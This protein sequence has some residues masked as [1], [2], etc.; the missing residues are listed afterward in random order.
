MS[1]HMA[2]R[3][4]PV[5]Q[6]VAQR[7]QA[8]TVPAP[9]RGIIESENFSF[10][11]PGAAIICD[12]WA[13]TMRGVKLRGG[14]IRW[15]V[16][17]DPLP[18]LSS[19]EYASGNVQYMFA[20]QQT[21]LYDVTAATPVLVKGGQLSGNY[22]AAQLATAA[23]DFLTAVND[24]GDGID[25]KCVFA[26]DQGE[27]LI[28]TGSNPSD[29]N[30]WRQEGRY[31]IPPPMGINAHI[32]LGGDLLIATVDG[33]VPVS[34]AITKDAEQLDLAMISHNIRSLWRTEAI[35]KR[36]WQ[37]TMKRWDE[38]GG[39]FVT[40]PGG[41]PGSQYCAIVNTGT[42]AWARFTG[43]DA[44]C[45]IRLRGDMFFGTQAGII[46]QADRTGYDDGVP[47]VASILGG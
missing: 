34:A 4:Q 14:H 45:F 6:Q 42:G 25:D 31:Q 17:P 46:M 12:N 24:A 18:V 2:F 13:P 11:Q 26:T 19:F 10:M 47:Y 1:Q 41:T 35:A 22:S 28:F 15:C 33:I 23:G 20:A 43:W 16:L 27:L 9:T 44:T 32:A 30:N 36:T 21:K 29:P 40:W 3:R 39:M 38:Y 5:P 7:H 8:M 37:W